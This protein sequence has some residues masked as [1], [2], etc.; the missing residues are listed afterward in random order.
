MAE[1]GHSSM[2]PPKPS[3]LVDAAHQDVCYAMLQEIEYNKF[4]TCAGT[5]WGKGP[6]DYEKRNLSHKQ[7]R[8]RAGEYISQ[9]QED[10]LQELGGEEPEAVREKGKKKKKKTKSSTTGTTACS[11][12]CT[13]IV[14]LPNRIENP[15][16][17]TFLHGVIK[18]CFG[19]KKN[20]SSKMSS[21]PDDLIFKVV[22][23]RAYTD[24]AT[25]QEKKTMANCY[26][27][28]RLY[29]LRLARPL[30][31]KSQVTTTEDVFQDFQKCHVELLCNEGYYRHILANMGK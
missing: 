12:P 6:S 28:L 10:L 1:I 23:N 20:F 15:P 26:F 18:K 3:N 13:E 21:P 8:K 5:S 4:T 16:I 25:G 11:T 27:H 19:C 17:V 31:E 30:L 2:K 24:K 14:T 9:L 22:C 29:C 7:Q